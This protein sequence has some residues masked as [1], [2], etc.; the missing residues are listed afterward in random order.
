MREWTKM[1]IALAIELLLTSSLG[2]AQQQ[3]KLRRLRIALPS[4]TIGATHF[5]VGKSLG[6]FESYGFEAQILVLEPRAALAALL[7]VIW[8]FTRPREPPHERR[9]VVCPCGSSWW[10][11]TVR[12]MRSSPLKRLPVSSS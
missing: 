12:I 5:Y 1:L 10:D 4:N 3:P 7:P 11:S 6:I 2:S 9:F 8:T